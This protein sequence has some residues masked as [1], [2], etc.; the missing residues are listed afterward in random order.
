[1]AEI[2]SVHNAVQ[3]IRTEKHC[4]ENAIADLLNDF[5]ARTGIRV[6]QIDTQIW[7][8]FSETSHYTAQVEAVI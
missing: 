2:K 6:S 1:M 8:S 5:T 3:S 4:L 7:D